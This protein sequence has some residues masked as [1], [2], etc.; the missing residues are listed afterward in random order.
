LRCIAIVSTSSR[1]VYIATA[2][3][4]Q[5]WTGIDSRA[6]FQA[7]SP[8]FIF[9]SHANIQCLAVEKEHPLVKRLVAGFF[10][11]ARSIPE[12]GKL[13]LVSLQ[14]EIQDMKLFPEPEAIRFDDQPF[15]NTLLVDPDI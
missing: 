7:F 3:R 2:H 4:L 15:K 10:Y 11:L 6:Q 13:H 9:N 14:Q 8:H 12:Q 1:P 5:S